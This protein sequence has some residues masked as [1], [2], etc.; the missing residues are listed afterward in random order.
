MK[1]IIIQKYLVL[2][3]IIS[4]C[5]LPT[6]T[7]ATWWK[8]TTWIKPEIQ[9]VE[10]IVE[11]PV[12]VEK[13]V[14]KIV[15]KVIEKPVEKIVTKTITVDNPDQ[16]AEIKKLTNQ[17][18]WYKTSLENLKKEYL[19]F[20]QEA[21][22]DLKK[23]KT[24]NEDLYSI[25]LNTISSQN[26]ATIQAKLNAQMAEVKAQTDQYTRDQ[27]EIQRLQWEACGQ[28]RY[29]SNTSGIER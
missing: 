11:K 12:E 24:Q 15:E 27:E 25:C 5:L 7:Y 4:I 16:V 21:I 22:D 1:N 18:F 23:A 17:V 13:I 29:C 19:S 6:L 8:P 28:G 20:I 14:E 26:V 2:A 3:S 10:K 9:Y